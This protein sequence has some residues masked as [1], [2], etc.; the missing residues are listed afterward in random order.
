MT[1]PEAA[2]RGERVKTA[3]AWLVALLAVLAVW[4]TRVALT[5]AIPNWNRADA[6]GLLKSDPALLYWFTERIAENEGRLPDDL[7][8]TRAV[9]WPAEVDARVEFPQAQMWLAANTWRWSGRALP[10]HEWCVALFSLLAASAGL[11]VF[12]LARELS[13]SRALGLVALG[14]WALLPA[15]WRTTSYVL[16]GE[17]LSFPAFAA[18]LWL[19]ARAARVRT[20]SS[21]LLAGLALLVAMVSWH[22][23]GFFVAL[24]AGAF[25]AWT[26]RSGENALRVRHAWLALL[27]FLLA[28]P[29][30]PFLRGKLQFLSLPVQ[31]AA[32]LAGAA[33]IERRRER[34]R[35]PALGP[36]ARAA[37]LVALLAGATGVALAASRAVGGGLGDYSHVFGLIAAKLANLGRLPADPAELP[38]EVRILWQGPF[39]T[40]QPRSLALH[41]NTALIGAAMLAVLAL[42]T[43][44]RGRGNATEAILALLSAVALLAAWLIL[45]TAILAAVLLPTAS[46]VAA[47]RWRAGRA[48][49]VTG[50]AALV[51]LAPPCIWFPEL[52]H[53]TSKQNN[54]YNPDHV[55]E[56]RQALAA[57]RAHVPAGEP[58]SSDEVNS[59]AV[60][61]HTGHPI[62]VQ[63]KYE[64][65]AARA[66]LEEYRSVAT[67]GTPDELARY[68]G[69]RRARH[70]LYDWRILWSSRYQAGIP[71]S[72]DGAR[73][74][75]A[76][77]M[78]MQ[79]PDRL[80]GF[81]LLWKSP[82]GRFRLYEL[83]P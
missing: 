57:I 48:R 80:P 47:A 43:W 52:L 12:G 69:E 49:L 71:S 27:P 16:L 55:R 3:V 25:L 61:A 83:A 19:L 65:S 41:L 58:V 37:L 1:T 54:W 64:S 32:A 63:P 7:A 34:S 18:H 30:E 9:Q 53:V 31:I 46:V 62:L 77:A 75:T 24:E 51:L 79:D 44:W 81:E 2:S 68:L 82:G 45:R 28:S 4:R 66:R 40:L 70:L 42:P 15:S 33:W 5:H 13:G 22:A 14:T 50:L 17:D 38:F 73:P 60:L 8:R 23:A 36:A 21:F 26:L 39:E 6:R 59:T 35:R 56:L 29:F 10:L 74:G 72:V 76:L 67:L 11:A 78:T 20:P